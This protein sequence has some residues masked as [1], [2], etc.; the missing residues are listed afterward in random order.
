M[1]STRT[2]AASSPAQGGSPE[3]NGASPHWTVALKTLD[4]GHKV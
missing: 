1:Q 3:Q 4:R 2:L